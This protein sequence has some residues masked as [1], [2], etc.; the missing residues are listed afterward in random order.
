MLGYRWHRPSWGQQ[1]AG[2]CT[3]PE[4]QSHS[5]PQFPPWHAFP[6]RSLPYHVPDGRLRPGGQ[7]DPGGPGHGH[8][9]LPGLLPVLM[10]GLDQEEPTAQWALQVEHLQQHLGPEPGHHETPPRWARGEW[11]LSEGASRRGLG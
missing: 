9:P 5:V 7:Q 3:H 4:E 8:R 2:C 1:V 10:W 6:C 11:G